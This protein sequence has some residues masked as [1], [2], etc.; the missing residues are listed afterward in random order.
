MI[1]FIF[2]LTQT[3][4]A[5]DQMTVIGYGEI[6]PSYPYSSEFQIARE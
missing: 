3:L 1:N 4:S 5:Y 6:K 2:L